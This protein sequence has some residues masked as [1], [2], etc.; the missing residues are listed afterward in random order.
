MVLLKLFLV[1]AA[2]ASLVFSFFKN[3]NKNRKLEALEAN[4]E[5]ESLAKKTAIDDRDAFARAA[6][7]SVKD[8]EKQKEKTL[9]AQEEAAQFKRG[10]ESRASEIVA[11]NS[12]IEKLE[13]ILEIRSNDIAKK[14]TEIK[15]FE[16]EQEELKNDLAAAQNEVAKLKKE[17]N[18]PKEPTLKEKSIP[19]L[20][21]LMSAGTWKNKKGDYLPQGSWPDKART[22][23]KYTIGK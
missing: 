3:R 23:K 4:L 1:V 17:L 18:K 2:L 12:K 21:K 16:K 9:K 13:Q 10:S 19:V 15:H 20:L 14:Q 8:F 7:A 11:M 22:L 6:E 5:A